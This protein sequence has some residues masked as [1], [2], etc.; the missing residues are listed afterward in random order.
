LDWPSEQQQQQQWPEEEPLAGDQS[1]GTE[2]GPADVDQ[3]PAHNATRVLSADPERDKHTR[4][5]QAPPPPKFPPKKKREAAAEIEDSILSRDFE[6][7]LSG[8]KAVYKRLRT[9]ERVALWATIAAFVASFSP[10]YYV[11]RTG[12]ISGVQTHGWIPAVL[13]GLALVL[14]YLRFSLRWGILPSIL[15][16]F[17][18]AGAAIAAVY[19]TLVPSVG[20]MRFGLPAT[21]VA[22]SVAAVAALLGMLSRT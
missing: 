2:P 20:A 16:F 8:A 21:A 14:L 9:P 5:V 19:F 1:M 17:V 11:R 12:L 22:A 18:T 4:V 10:W 6:I 7:A 3:E 13:T 15:Q